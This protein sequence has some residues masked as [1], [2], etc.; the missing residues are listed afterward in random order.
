M[1]CGVW[2]V[3]CEVWGVKS[4]VWSVECEVWSVDCEVWSVKCEVW[5]VKCEVWSVKCEVWSVQWEACSVSV[6]CGVWSVKCGVRSAQSAVWRVQCVVWSVECEDCQVWSVTWS[7]KCDMWNKTPVSQS[8]RTHGL[9]WGTAHASSIDE[10]GLIYIYIYLFKA[11]SA[12]PRAGT[13][14]IILYVQLHVQRTQHHIWIMCRVS[15]IAPDIGVC[16]YGHAQTEVQHIR[17]WDQTQFQKPEDITFSGN[18]PLS[19][20]FC[21][22]KSQEWS[23]G[24]HKAQ[25]KRCIDVAVLPCQNPGPMLASLNSIKPFCCA[26][27]CLATAAWWVHWDVAPEIAEG[28]YWPADANM[29]TW[30]GSSHLAPQRLWRGFT[31]WCL[32]DFKSISRKLVEDS[33]KQVSS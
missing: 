24:K 21:A 25:E 1:K 16:V 28:A 6:K 8:A 7:F 20:E 3:Q 15:N 29:Q 32:H 10:K 23:Y 9:R 17:L 11:T 30:K 18:S 19:L 2:R 4:A 14:G 5:T 26:W 22:E 13:T 27:C 31:N 33:S 12:P